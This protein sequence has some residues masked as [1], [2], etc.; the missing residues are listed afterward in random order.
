MSIYSSVEHLNLLPC[1]DIVEEKVDTTSYLFWSFFFSFGLRQKMVMH[2]QY[3][4][5]RPKLNLHKMFKQF[6]E[7]QL[8]SHLRSLGSLGGMSLCLGIIHLVRTWVYQRIRNG[9]FSGNF[10]HALNGWSLSLFTEIWWP[11]NK[12]QYFGYA[13]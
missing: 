11:N 6:T 8:Y 1:V 3:L 13:A 9:S 2:Q 12:I 5:R 4:P 7:C 10:S